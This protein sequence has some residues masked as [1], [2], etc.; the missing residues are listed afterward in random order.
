MKRRSTSSGTRE[1]QI[2]TPV[3]SSPPLTGQRLEGGLGPRQRRSPERRWGGG[4]FAGT[5]WG[6]LIKPKPTVRVG[7]GSLTP[8]HESQRRENYVHPHT[9]VQRFTA[10][11]GGSVRPLPHAC[12]GFAVS[13]APTTVAPLKGSQ[14]AK[15]RPSAGGPGGPATRPGTAPPA[16]LPCNP[17][18]R[19]RASAPDGTRNSKRAG[20][21]AGQGPP[22]RHDYS[23]NGRKIT[24]EVL[25][26]AREIRARRVRASRAKR[27]REKIGRAHV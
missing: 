26:C 12:A 1:M 18:P 27:A 4:P 25:S 6:R 11:G 5:F 8:G 19:G 22:G 20:R 13:C 23:R 2:K 3:K 16:R 15:H 9:C 14:Q 24:P 21:Q 10:P 17:G 7:S